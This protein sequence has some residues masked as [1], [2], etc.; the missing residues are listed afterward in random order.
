M[1]KCFFCKNIIKSPDLNFTWATC[2]HGPKEFYH[3][4]SDNRTLLW[5][6]DDLALAINHAKNGNDYIRCNNK[7]IYIG[8]FPNNFLD[9]YSEKDA[10]NLINQYLV[11]S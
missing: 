11:F 3:K 4:S 8:N 10:I 2:F 6:S 7:K 5:F 1:I 9:I